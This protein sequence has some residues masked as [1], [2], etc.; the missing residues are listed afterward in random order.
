MEPQVVRHWAW[1][2]PFRACLGSHLNDISN[3]KHRSMCIHIKT[4]TMPLPFCLED[5]Q[6]VKILGLPQHMTPNMFEWYH[7]GPSS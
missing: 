1:A 6:G 4:G 2:L 7:H 5:I 3:P